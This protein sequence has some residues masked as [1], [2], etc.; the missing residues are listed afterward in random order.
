MAEHAKLKVC[1]LLDVSNLGMLVHGE[2]DDDASGQEAVQQQWHIILL[3]PQLIHG[4]RHHL[5]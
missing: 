3:G 1:Y 5:G 2:R 4:L